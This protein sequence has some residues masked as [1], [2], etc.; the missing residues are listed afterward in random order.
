MNDTRRVDVHRWCITYPSVQ[1][2]TKC[3]C[4]VEGA[5][6][7]VMAVDASGL[8]GVGCR[9]RVVVCISGPHLVWCL[10]GFGG[11]GGGYCSPGLS[12]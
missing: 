1:I 7:L 9:L 11:W 6:N 12:A 4:Y 10:G 2:K 5:I 3:V 8:G